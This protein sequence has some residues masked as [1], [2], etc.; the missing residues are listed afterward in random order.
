MGPEVVGKGVPL[1][2]EED[3]ES[4]EERVSPRHT[5]RECV[6]GPCHMAAYYKTKEALRAANGKCNGLLTCLT[7]Q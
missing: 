7:F 3:L 6:G 1:D 5:R 2:E 4:E